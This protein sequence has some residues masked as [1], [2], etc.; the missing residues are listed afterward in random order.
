MISPG[1][2]FVWKYGVPKGKYVV[3]CFM[4]SKV[5]GTPHALMGMFKLFH[6]N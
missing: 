5:D 3:M 4:P 2:S 1:H 6:L